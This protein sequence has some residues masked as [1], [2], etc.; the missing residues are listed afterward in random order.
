MLHGK[1]NW[2]K[3][4]KVGDRTLPDFRQDYKDYNNES[5]MYGI[6]TKTHTEIT[7]TE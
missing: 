3:K 7:A 6:G 4:N 5:I 1:G 2:R